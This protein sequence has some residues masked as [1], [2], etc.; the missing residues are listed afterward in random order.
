MRCV[1]ISD[2]NMSTVNICDVM[3]KSPPFLYR[4]C[5]RKFSENLGEMTHLRT[6]LSLLPVSNPTMR[7][8]GFLHP[9]IPSSS[10]M[11]D[12]SSCEAFTSR[13]RLFGESY[14][15]KSLH[16]IRRNPRPRAS[17]SSSLVEGSCIL[18]KI[19]LW[20]GSRVAML[21]TELQCC[22]EPQPQMKMCPET[23][24]SILHR[25]SSFSAASLR[26]FLCAK[27]I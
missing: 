9:M 10:P 13:T 11:A 24:V 14:I 2:D 4:S 17:S 26:L 21:V 22:S 20:K 3:D 19:C 15:C 12:S 16:S 8:P 25:T 1:G 23:A 7:S 27:F 18:S 6:H 5:L